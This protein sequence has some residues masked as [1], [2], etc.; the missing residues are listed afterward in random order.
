MICSAPARLASPPIG[1]T[2]SASLRRRARPSRW[3]A[4]ARCTRSSPWSKGKGLLRQAGRLPG[5]HLP[6]P[7][8]IGVDVGEADAEAIG[9]P[10][11][12][13]ADP[14]GPGQDNGIAE[15]LGLDVRRL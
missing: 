15:V 9:P 1:T 3:R 11:R 14:T 8:L 13:D 7:T 10:V 2:G 6:L 5:H 12:H 4:S